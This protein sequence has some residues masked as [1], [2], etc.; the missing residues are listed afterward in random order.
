VFD[1]IHWAEPTLLDLIRHIADSAAG[2]VLVLCLA[3]P[4]L[5]ELYPD[6]AQGGAEAPLISLEPLSSE[7]MAR[8]VDNALGSGEVAEEV[9]NRILEAA[10]GNPLFVEQML[11]MLVDEGTLRLEDGRWQPTVELAEVAVPP[12]IQALLT[13]RLEQL[14]RDSRAV[15]EP[16]SVAGL[17]FAQG[18]VESIVDDAL[19]LDVGAELGSLTTKQLLRRDPDGPFPEDGYQ[20]EHALVR[21]A[22]YNRLLKRTRA[23]LHE[24]FVDWADRLN[25][26]RGREAEFQEILGYHLEQAHG[27]LSELGP[28][29]DHG[30]Q[31]G[32]RA[33]DRLA[34]AGKRAFSRGD[35]PAASGLLRRAV[36][37]MPVGDPSR[38]ELLPELGEALVDTGA[39]NAAEAFMK[40]A[41]SG[42]R[43]IGDERLEARAQ[44]VTWLL[45]GYTTDGASWAGKAV[46]GAAEVLPVF[47]RASDDVGLA[48]TYRLLAWAHGTTCQFGD[49][50]AAAERAIAHAERAGDER[51]RR[52]ASAQYA[53]AAVWG[54][55]PVP[56][57]IAHC[58]K[59]V[60]QAS[61]DRRTEGLV[62][63]LLARLEAMRGDFPR[64][65]ALAREARATLG[66]MAKGVVAASTS[67]DSCGVHT[68]AGDLAA[69]EHDLRRDY[70]AL[71]E[72]GEKYLLSTVAAELSW[73]L[74]RAHRDAEAERFTRIAAKLA[75][76][77]DL[78][79]QALWRWVRAVLMARRGE[80]EPAKALAHEAT[81][82]LSE[83]DSLV[84]L[85][86]ALVGLSEVA[87]IA[88]DSKEASA[89]A[90]QALDLYERKGDVVS[91]A[92]TR[93]MLASLPVA[94]RV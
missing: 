18:A 63:S 27:Y 15:V 30:R 54:P 77:D 53:M 35:M 82:L 86:D 38:L 74:A 45:K 2:T 89:S 7:A 75:D 85:A 1:D 9:R 17:R 59:I 41:I 87:A 68:L 66:D 13:A 70:E 84:A 73:V 76:E 34:A 83:T 47:E 3:R 44:V 11:S 26:E 20:F 39:F 90:A 37:L 32:V 62:N 50:A 88:G 58:E 79:S 52:W 72:M 36:D 5:L 56:E 61:E 69:A 23:D 14:E 12:T 19:H 91:A 55:T 93:S 10:A 43:Q 25:R 81:D 71:H 22:A 21:D 80:I 64:A 29:D 92:R 65:R 51:Q 94:E 28:L 60:E 49:V 42:A 33:A 6:W 16:A 31:L 40:E 78:T 57:A 24:R 46:D 8:I 67:L 4:D 48:A